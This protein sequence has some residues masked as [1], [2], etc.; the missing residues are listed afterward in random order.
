[1]EPGDKVDVMVIAAHPDDAEI[2]MGGTIAALLAAGKSLVLVDLTNGEPTPHGSPA[3]RKKESQRAAEILGVKE[4][5]TLDITN[6]EILDTVA[7]RRKLA[8]VIRQYRPH[9]LF[10]PFW[11]DAHPDHIY[12]SLLS[13]ASRFYAKFTKG[14]LPFEPHYPTQT[15]HYFSLH[16]RLK[17]NPSFIFDISRFMDRKIEALGAYHSQFIAHLGNSTIFDFLRTENA[18]WGTQVGCSY[19]EPFVKREHV[20]ISAPDAL[21]DS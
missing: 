14:D 13:V 16:L 10:V 3:I 5:V 12:A 7:N 9:T 4:R 11:D 1:M 21:L 17:I 2:G 18:Y 15:L 19:G 20:R 6:R 8:G